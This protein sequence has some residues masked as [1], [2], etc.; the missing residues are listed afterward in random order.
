MRDYNQL[1]ARGILYNREAILNWDKRRSRLL[2]DYVNSNLFMMTNGIIDR[3]LSMIL[4]LEEREDEV[5][6]FFRNYQQE[7]QQVDD[8]L[9]NLGFILPDC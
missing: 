8:L 3:V 4:V 7:Q 5:L 1:F 6:L 2:S 9:S